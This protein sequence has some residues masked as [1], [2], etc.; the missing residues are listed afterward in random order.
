MTVSLAPS[1]EVDVSDEVSCWLAIDLRRLFSRSPPIQSR[2]LSEREMEVSNDHLHD[3]LWLRFFGTFWSLGEVV[4]AEN[5][6]PF[7][8]PHKSFR[9]RGLLAWRKPLDH[10][11]VSSFSFLKFETI[12]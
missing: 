3:N 4:S 9:Y 1:V 10:L 7:L 12:H 6:L 2:S 8:P 5:L 11:L